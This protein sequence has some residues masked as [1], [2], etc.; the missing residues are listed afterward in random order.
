MK[1]RQAILVLLM[2]AV[3]LSGCQKTP[4]EQIVRQKG[5]ESIEN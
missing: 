2:G 4:Q 5:Q 3:L 1:K